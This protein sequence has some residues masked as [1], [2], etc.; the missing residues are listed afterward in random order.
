MREVLESG[1][2]NTQRGSVFEANW[3][4]QFSADQG[5]IKDS[6]TLLVMSCRRSERQAV[7]RGEDGQYLKQNLGRRR[8]RLEHLHAPDVGQTL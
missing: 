2:G 3:E 4:Q 8:V 5:Q 6:M 1:S 7:D